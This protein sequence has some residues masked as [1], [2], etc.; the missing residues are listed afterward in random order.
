MHWVDWIIVLI[1]LVVVFWIA[2]KSRHYVKGVSDFLAGGRVA[3]RYVISVASGEAAMGLVS[4]VAGF[5]ML[6]LVGFACSGYWGRITSIVMIVLGLWGYCVYRFRETMAMTMGQFL[7]IRY[8]KTLRIYAATLQATA[9]ILNYSIFPAIGARA[10]IYF[11]D[12]PLQ[13]KIFGMA[14]PTFLLVMLVMLSI[15]VAIIALGGQITIMITDCIQG[16]ISYPI[17]LIIVAFIFF[18][19]S[20]SS[21]MLP[22]LLNRSP[23]ESM[24]NPYDVKNLRDFN[25][26]AIGVG[27]MSA[28][29]NQMAWSSSQGFT[30]SAINAHEQ[31]MGSILGTWRGGFSSMM[32]ILL[33]IVGYTFLNGEKFEHDATNVR[34]HLAI[35]VIADVVP[36]PS[37]EHVKGEIINYV[38]KTEI[39]PQTAQAIAALKGQDAKQKDTIFKVAKASLQ[40]NDP[41]K[42]QE[43]G[44]IYNQMLVLSAIKGILPVGLIGLFCVIMIFLMISCDTTTIHSWGS[45]IVQDIIVPLRKKPFEP[46]QQLIL[47]RCMMVVVAVI[48]FLFSAMFRQVDYIIMFFVITSAIWLGGAGSCIVFGL[49][50]RRGTSWGA[51]ASLFSGA[52]IAGSGFICQSI[53]VAHLYPWLVKG[54]FI[55]PV[56]TILESLSKPLNPY[57]IWIVEP[58]KFPINSQEI[59]F[60]AMTSSVFLY[61]IVSLLT[62]KKP[63]NMERMLHR[64]KYRKEGTTDIQKVPFSM[65]GIMGAMIGIDS[66]FSRGDKAIA[67]SV[68]VYAVIWGLGSWIFAVAW[69]SVTPWTMSWWANW[70]YLNN[71][72][73][74]GIIG[75]VTTV[76]FTIGGTWDLCRLF[77]RLKN[78]PTNV[79]DD[80]R[81]IG[82]VS[83]ADIDDKQNQ[84]I[85]ET[86]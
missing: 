22:C 20:W 69:N 27:L 31:K 29:L 70:F 77:A 17:Y 67:Y 56:T 9:G 61:V 74:A 86:V 33:V 72:I 24:L 2:I 71:I 26:F 73:L 6:Y 13:V 79:H 47:L 23:G 55:Q 50:W 66:G 75:I 19:F 62:F 39:T 30:V 15:A 4:L 76:W 25:V 58:G 48:A 36:T 8:N 68:F 60:V 10:L 65:R 51:F 45:I 82:H 54:N 84:S 28:V 41:A 83:A 63:F 44:T 12:L 11:F 38:D 43:F 85:R 21:D 16:L 64:G 78:K 57:V 81:V 35:K 14:C 3:G 52:V 32:F 18:S 46:K 40:A 7:E 1:P 59:F 80:G 42:A 5:E 37:G 34:T 49:Y 53:W